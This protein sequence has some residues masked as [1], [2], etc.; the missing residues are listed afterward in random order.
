MN[1]HPKNDIIATEKEWE[2]EGERR[3]KRVSDRERGRQRET[4][5]RNVRGG[6]RLDKKSEGPRTSIN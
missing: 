5:K 6:H 2:S 3:R 4:K 1:H